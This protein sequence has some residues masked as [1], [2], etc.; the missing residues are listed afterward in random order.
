MDAADTVVHIERVC[1]LECATTYVKPADGAT[2]RRNPGCPECGYV[3]WIFA[4]VPSL[5]LRSGLR[6][7]AAGQLPGP[8]A[9]SH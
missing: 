6:R 5:S 3:G 7:F 9:Q 1:C 4:L 8:A 2:V